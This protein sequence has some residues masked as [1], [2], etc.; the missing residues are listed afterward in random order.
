MWRDLTSQ[1]PMNDL[2]DQVHP[3]KG[4]HLSSDLA[5]VSWGGQNTP[6]PWVDVR[7]GKSWRLQGVKKPDECNR[8]AKP[9]LSKKP[10]EP[11]MTLSVRETD[12]SH[13]TLTPHFLPAK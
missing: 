10:F 5:K 1:K 12:V 2:E 13:Q 3:D 11:M 6:A 9:Q 4:R 8:P 7:P